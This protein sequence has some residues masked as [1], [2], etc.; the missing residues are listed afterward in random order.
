M[1][2]HLLTALPTILPKAIDWA[3]AQS[4]LI[5]QQGRPLDGTL[6]NIARQ[7]GVAEPDQIR[8]LEVQRLPLPNDPELQKAAIATGLLGT[9]MIGLTLGYG[10][11]VCQGHSTVRLLSHEFRHVYQYESAGSIASFLP[12][13]LEQIATLGYRNAPL[14]VDARAHEIHR[15]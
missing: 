10:V 8:V 14:E 4:D 2:F 11:Y 5:A 15:A 7:V 13:Y 1:M 9:G 12:I 6:I 3:E